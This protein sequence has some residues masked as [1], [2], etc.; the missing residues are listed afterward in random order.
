MNPSAKFPFMNEW[1]KPYPDTRGMD[2]T[3]DCVTPVCGKWWCTERKASC[4][5]YCHLQVK[6]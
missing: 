4:N 1:L 5:E 6:D 2:L 3:K